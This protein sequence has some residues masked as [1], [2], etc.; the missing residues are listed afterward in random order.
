MLAD[1]LERSRQTYV[2]SYDVATIHAGFA[3]ADAAFT[4]LDKAIEERASFLL[5]LQWDPR[6]DPLRGDPRLRAL[7]ERVGPPEYSTQEFEALAG[8]PVH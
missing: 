5:H 2:S 7:L 8:W 6:F 3:D 1:L 4:W